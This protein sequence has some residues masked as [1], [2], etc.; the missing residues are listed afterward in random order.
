MPSAVGVDFRRTRW[1]VIS[2]AFLD[3]LSFK[4]LVLYAKG[5]DL[6][7]NKAIG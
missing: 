7:F 3:P 1:E 2:L 6:S 5:N 4:G